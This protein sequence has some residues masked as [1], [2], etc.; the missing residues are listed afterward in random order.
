MQA[1]MCERVEAADKRSWEE[2]VI[3]GKRIGSKRSWDE[4]AG[5]FVKGKRR[6]LWFTFRSEEVD[7]TSFRNEA[8]EFAAK[9]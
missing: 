6:P 3:I 2:K 5:S 1:Y 8:G 4:R 7:G 9:A